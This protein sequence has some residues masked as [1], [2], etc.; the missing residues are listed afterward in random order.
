MT[1]LATIQTPAD[2]KRL[3]RDQ[4]PQLAQEIRD[5]LIE[6][7]SMTGGHI[8]AS[9]GVVELS[10]ALLYE[11]DSP[12]DKIVWDVGHQAYAWKLLTGRNDA[13]PT[14]RQTEGI[15]GFLKRTESE[16]DHFGAGHAGTA[17][18]AALG[19]ATARDLKG[20]AHKVVA[21]VGD[22]ALTCGLSY[23]GMNNAGHSER[24][25]ILIV[26]DNGMSISP[27]VGAIST[28]L[29]RIVADPR[30]NKL[31]EKI[32]GMTF[33]LGGVFGEGVVDFAKN[34]EESVKNMFSPGMLF[35]ELGFRYFGPIDG[36]DL[37]KL[38]DTLKFVRGMSG[39]RVVHVMTQKGKGFGFAES[40]QEKWH[41]LAAY[42]PVTGEARKKA[43]GPPAWTQVFGEGLAALGSEH[44]ELVAITAAMP[45]GTGTNVFQKKHPE[46][47]FDV[48]IAEGH[49]VTF[50]GGLATQG[51]RPVVA[52][53][54]TFLQRAYDNIIHDIAVQHLPV[55]FCMDRAGLVGEDGQT[56]MG[57]Y[58]I[59]YMLAVPGMTVT[60]PKDG[61]ELVGLLRTALA[62]TSG[63]FSTRY[64]RD[65]A[66]AEPRPAAEIPAVPYGTWEQLRSGKDIAILAVG[67]MV[68]PAQEAADLLA[69]DGIDCAVINA[70]F[71]KPLDHA[72]LELLLQEHRTLVT[73]EEGTIVNGFGAYLAETLQTTHPEVRVVA[74]GIPDR[75]IEQAPR[76]EQLEVCGL[77]AAGIARRITALAHEES[78]EAR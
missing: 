42:D 63:P 15:S 49:A 75:L 73:I 41:G 7:V 60:A 74:L 61:D 72:M 47:F 70:R 10:V 25:I 32:K 14:L 22:G 2:L 26:N 67:T 45:S 69:P 9:L 50:A 28:M 48:G 18:S 68:R 30:T 24:D 71:I 54:S 55:T 17:M 3:R 53:Y 37:N 35:E 33:A 78:L 56:H 44:P 66:P 29:G 5:R 57:L 59:A 11:F 13:F 34:L 20:E 39:P 77:T 31:R 27:N 6:C 65:K 36:H 58:D 51:I 38:C 40:N 1:L 64:P 4:L 21:I 52:I 16:H 46:R 62:H 76:V 43:S 23:E 12:A 8:G 19:M